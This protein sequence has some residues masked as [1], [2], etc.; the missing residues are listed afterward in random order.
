METIEEFG[1]LRLRFTDPIQHDYEVIRPIVLFAKPVAER[2]RETEIERTTVSEKARRFVTEGM[3][4]L[5]D[6]R[7]TK[8]GRKEHEYPDPVASYILYLK[9]VYPPI[10][11]QEIVRILE[12]KFGYETNH[13]T[14]KSFLERHAIPVQLELELEAFHDFEAAYE[15]RWTVVRMYYEGWDKKSIAGVLKL[16]RRHV[17]RLIEAFEQDGFAGLEDK[18][19]RPANHPENQM[20]LSFM[21]EVLKVQ[22]EYPRAG[23]FRVHGLLEKEMG[24]DTPSER[25][26]GRAMAYNRFFQ[27]APGPWPPPPPD[28][29][30]WDP[31]ELPYRPLYGHHYWFID[32]RYLVQL[33]GGWVYSLCVIEGYS[34]KIL[35]GM[36]SVYQDELAVLQLLHAALSEYGCPAGLVSDNAGVFNAHAYG[37]VL[38]T[39]KIEPC[40]IEKRQAW[41]NLIE[42][43]F[44]VQLRLADA[45]FEQ[46][47]TLEEIQ[48]QHAAFIQIFNTTNHWAHREREDGKRTPVDVLGWERG[49]P[50]ELDVLRRAFRHLQFPRTVNKGGYVSVQRFYIYAEHGLAK[51]R[52]SVWIYDDRLNI[53][54]RQIL[55]ARYNCK[56]NRQEKLLKSVSQPTLYQTQFA[57]PQLELFEL[58]DEQWRKV[59]ERLPNIRR[60][61]SGPFGKQLPLSGLE[62]ALL[63]F[64]F[65]R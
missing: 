32:I 1:Q 39:L 31:V 42:A 60:K 37:Q 7:S 47:T 16:S 6:Q 12:R 44:K 29:S 43:Q 50:V 20:T 35:A 30:D 40:Y 4:G 11:Y 63:L 53:E 9:Q 28:R 34:R 13:H 55:L 25:T 27:D 21:D 41:Q 58:D 38:S 51:Q 2:S 61:S 26:V 57:S 33:D 8:A 64:L 3:M 18:R 46:A 48:N 49:R 14:V 36:A 65:G 10:H 15:A 45:K 52:V 56:L 23:R 19:T 17:G 24:E 62:L 59:W 5:V 54:Y 22:Q